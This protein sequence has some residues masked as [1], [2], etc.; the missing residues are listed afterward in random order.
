MILAKGSNEAKQGKNCELHCKYSTPTK[1]KTS[2]FETWARMTRSRS[3][4]LFCERVSVT[5]L[6]ER[7]ITLPEAVS[8]FHRAGRLSRNIHQWTLMWACAL[9]S[10]SSK[11]NK[12]KKTTKKREEKA[13]EKDFQFYF[14][15]LTQSFSQSKT[16]QR[17]SMNASQS[18][19][20]VKWASCYDGNW[21]NQP[22]YNNPKVAVGFAVV[23]DVKQKG[24]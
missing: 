10:I 3:P 21:L 20:A 11:K 6:T 19:T 2:P 14:V 18:H 24:V 8:P 1:R 22:E 16:S 7:S 23:H 5:D 15:P 4:A 17:R 9:K 12:K 13:G